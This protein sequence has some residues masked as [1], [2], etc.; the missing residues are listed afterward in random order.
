MSLISALGLASLVFV[1]WFTMRAYRNNDASVG[2]RQSRRQ[3]IVEVWIGIVVGFLLNFCLNLVLLPLVGAKFTL[4]DNFWLGCIYTLASIVLAY[5][6]R[7]W[8]DGYIHD[9]AARATKRMT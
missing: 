5:S 9:F 4:A 3:A 6:I 7:R 2:G 8:A 1:V